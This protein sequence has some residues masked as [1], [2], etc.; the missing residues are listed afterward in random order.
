MIVYRRLSTSFELSTSTTLMSPTGRPAAAT[1]AGSGC[2]ASARCDP[3]ANRSRTRFTGPYLNQLTSF[4]HSVASVAASGSP[5]SALTS[6]DLPEF[7]RPPTA[8]RSRSSASRARTPAIVARTG[9]WAG[10]GPLAGT[11]SPGSGSAASA[12][13]HAPSR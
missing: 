12:R 1:A 3:S 11:A 6:V 8:T 9:A 2:A 7:I 5:S 10:A 4:V 13:S